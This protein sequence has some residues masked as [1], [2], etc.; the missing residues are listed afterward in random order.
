MATVRIFLMQFGSL[1]FSCTRD[2][3]NGLYILAS[4]DCRRAISPDEA[5]R[6]AG[7]HA[8][9]QWRGYVAVAKN[10]PMRA[11]AVFKRAWPS[12]TVEIG[13]S[14]SGDAVYVQVGDFRAELD[15]GQMAI[16]MAVLNQLDAD[17]RAVYRAASE[18][19]DL[20][21]AQSLCFPIYIPGTDGKEWM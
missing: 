21:V 15:E 7:A 9:L 6:L 2:M 17:V 10:R 1:D 18:A 20:S 14:S 5:S 4:R 8:L 19:P 11:G 13:I 16:L 12:L 3:A